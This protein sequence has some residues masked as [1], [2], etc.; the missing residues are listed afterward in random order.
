MERVLIATIRTL[1]DPLELRWKQ[2]Q[3]QEVE[4]KVRP[5]LDSCLFQWQ[6]E[7]G[8]RGRDTSEPGFIVLSVEF[9]SVLSGRWYLIGET[10]TGY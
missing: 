2:R 3:K 6:F 7:R 10:C 9:L 4:A 8:T 1:V 5:N